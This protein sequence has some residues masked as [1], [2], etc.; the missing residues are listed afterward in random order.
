MSCYVLV[1]LCSI[2][3]CFVLQVH[4][5]EAY[6]NLCKVMGVGITVDSIQ[7]EVDA[8]LAA[9]GTT[10]S[11][12]ES[13][14][15]QFYSNII[16]KR[17]TASEGGGA[18][19]GLGGGDGNGNGPSPKRSSIVA[20]S[21]VMIINSYLD[22]RPF[23]EALNKVE[24]TSFANIRAAVGLPGAAF[25]VEMQ[26]VKDKVRNMQCMY[27]CIAVVVVNPNTDCVH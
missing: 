22:D 20:R 24:L 21:K 10:I 18:A 14:D 4:D 6:A 1:I 13:A 2:V 15:Q 17:L 7:K 9:S 3:L 12:D 8:Q 27:V 19:K 26:Q 25:A 11:V 5:K 16:I 23:C